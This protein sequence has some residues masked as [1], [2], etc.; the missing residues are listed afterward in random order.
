MPKTLYNRREDSQG[1]IL[2]PC[3]SAFGSKRGMNNSAQIMEGKITSV[4]M[5]KLANGLRKVFLKL[6]YKNPKTVPNECLA[7][8]TVCLYHYMGL[9]SPVIAFQVYGRIITKCSLF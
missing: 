8:N 9:F 2:V 7:L 3:L 4:N 1:L 6:D 5:Y